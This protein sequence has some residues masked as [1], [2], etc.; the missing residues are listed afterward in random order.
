M[1]INLI[2]N[3]TVTAKFD[4]YD[5][6]LE[7]YDFTYVDDEGDEILISFNKIS[8]EAL[9]QFDLMQESFIGKEFKISYKIETILEEEE[10]E[11]E[12]VESY[13]IIDLELK[14]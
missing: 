3:E 8:K 7:T 2:V 10:N 12:G 5:E 11:E 14:Q 9:L 6:D 4:G 1:F 13:T